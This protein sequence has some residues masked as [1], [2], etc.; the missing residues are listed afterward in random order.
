MIVYIVT[1]LW[2]HIYAYIKIEEERERDLYIDTDIN[3]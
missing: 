1:Y 2:R 3:I